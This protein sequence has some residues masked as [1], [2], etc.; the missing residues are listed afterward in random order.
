VLATHRPPSPHR[1]RSAPHRR[2]WKHEQ[3]QCRRHP[4]RQELARHMGRGRAGR[5]GH[6]GTPG[7]A[8]PT[9]YE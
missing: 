9:S 5:Q 2:H 6:R 4:T 1:R 8:R 7:A 3:G